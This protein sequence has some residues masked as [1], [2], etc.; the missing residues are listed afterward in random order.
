MAVKL[1]PEDIVGNKSLEDIILG[2]ASQ[3]QNANGQPDTLLTPAGNNGVQVNSPEQKSSPDNPP[4]APQ[5]NSP[6]PEVVLNIDAERIKKE[7]TPEGTQP[8]QQPDA[9]LQPYKT[10]IEKLKSL[11]VNS[12]EDLEKIISKPSPQIQFPDEQSRK[13]YESLKDGKYEEVY[14]FVDKQMKLRNLDKM[15]SA[16]VVKMMYRFQHPEWDEQDIE[17]EFQAKFSGLNDEDE[18]AVRRAKRL[19]KSEEQAA[20]QYLNS[21]RQDIKLPDIHPSQPV[22]DPKVVEQLRNQYVNSLRSIKDKFGF[23]FELKDDDGE[24]KTRFVI[25]PK[26]RDEFFS[27]MENFDLDKFFEDNYFR[28]GNYDTERLSRDMWLISRDSQGVA[29]Y[30]KL[31]R[32]QIR[33]VYA[34]AKKQILKYLKGIDREMVSPAPY[35]GLSANGSARIDEVLNKIS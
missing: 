10:I 14:D 23:E 18:A 25:D 22:I 34:E 9:D 24:I 13:L 6:E 5:A 20:R 1:S 27:K 11:G 7:L 21:L 26:E 32:S 29:N 8:T 19:L 17:D 33:Q 30:E 16:S 4:I 2:K 3:M 15:D 35:G 28:N 12:D 31:I